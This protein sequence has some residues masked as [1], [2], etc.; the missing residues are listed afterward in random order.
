MSES[1]KRGKDFELKVAK[2]IRSKLGARVAR[3]RRSG[4]GHNKTDISDF[5][6][7]IPLHIECKAQETIK[8]KEWFRQADGTAPVFHAPT[9]IFDSDGEMLATLRVTDL[10]NFLVEIKDLRDENADLRMPTT[11]IPQGLPMGKENMI[12]QTQLDRAVS[13]KERKIYYCRNDHIAD[14]NGR[15]LYKGCKYSVGYRPPKGKS[16]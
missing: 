7:D 4:A 13:V 3:D 10:L 16:K 12:T 14:V 1:S 11:T 5:Y 2:L 9:V 15:C 8:I 6:N